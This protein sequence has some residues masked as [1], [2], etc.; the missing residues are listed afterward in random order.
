LD[1]NLA[2][3]A[4]KMIVRY[5]NNSLFYKNEH[6]A[7]VGDVITSSI[8][9]CRLNGINPLDYLSALMHN[10]S[11]VFANPTAW[12]PW[13]YRE[14]LH[15]MEQPVPLSNSPPIIGHPGAIGVA[16]PQ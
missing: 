11:A 3:Q 14:T 9:T 7:Y 6:G 16:V 15:A 13:N 4:L 10:R 1:N 8:E 12:F 2:E 5:R